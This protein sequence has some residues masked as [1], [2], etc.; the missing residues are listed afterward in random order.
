VAETPPRLVLLGN[1]EWRPNADAADAMVRMWP[2]ITTNVPDAELWLVG[3]R[4]GGPAR[5][6]PPGVTDLG[7]VEDVGAT[8]AGCRALAAP[9]A[10]GDGVR[11]K[12]LEAAARGLPVVA[13]KEAIGSIEASLDMTPAHD[14][15]DFVARCT[16]LLL[17]ADA[18][19]EEGARLH[20]VN[21]RRWTDRVG[22]DAVLDW[23]DR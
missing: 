23:I 5:D 15:A 8:L 9:V 7:F 19:A 21:A 2:Q 3:P 4:P 16:T 20:A 6:L 18:A 11:V 1:R 13:T 14:D 10:V 17:D 22:Q 12:L